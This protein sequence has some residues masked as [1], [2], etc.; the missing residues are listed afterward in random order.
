MSANSLPADYEEVD[1]VCGRS[2]QVTEKDSLSY[3]K[4]LTRVCIFTAVTAHL[5]GTLFPSD[6]RIP[7]AATIACLL[8]ARTL[9][10]VTFSR[11]VVPLVCTPLP[12]WRSGYWAE[13]SAMAVDVVV[14]CSR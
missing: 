5:P 10:L 13:V 2:K 8:L 12:V 3:R 4:H 1:G 9:L 6:V 7:L 11:R 14:A